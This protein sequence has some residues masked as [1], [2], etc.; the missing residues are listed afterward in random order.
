MKH[1][2]LINLLHRAAAA[3]ETP[4][5]LTEADKKALVEDLVYAAEEV[6]ASNIVP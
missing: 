2:E 6:N 4:S 3:L 1:R 5:D